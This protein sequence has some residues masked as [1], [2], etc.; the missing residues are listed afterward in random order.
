[1][2]IAPED[3]AAMIDVFDAAGN[4]TTV[5]A[6]G[7]LVEATPLGPGATLLASLA[8]QR[9]AEGTSDSVSC[10]AD[11]RYVAFVSS[12]TNLV[13]L[14]SN[15]VPDVFVADR[16]TGAVVCA[17]MTSGHAFGDGASASPSISADGRYVAFESQASNL[18]PGDTNSATDVF[19]CDL[20]TQQVERVSDSGSAPPVDTSINPSIS[21]DGRYVAF[22]SSGAG[23]LP[24]DTDPDADIYVYDRQTDTLELDTPISGTSPCY[25]PAISADGRYVAFDCVGTMGFPNDTNGT[26]DAFV[27]DRTNGTT[28]RVSQNAVGVAGSAWSGDV[29]ISA[30]GR[31]VSFYTS[32]SNLVPGHPALGVIDVYLCD[33]QTHTLELVSWSGTAYGD[34]MSRFGSVSADGRYVAFSSRATN[35]ASGSDT[36]GRRTSSSATVCSARSHGSAMVSAA[37]RPTAPRC[38]RP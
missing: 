36:N 19:V 3:V 5:T 6:K 26:D 27:Y 4:V 23:L 20:Q 10:S 1:M 18:A 35:L 12:A 38:P 25:R 24:T 15:G 17:S 31:Y 2:G 32:S 29:S 11:G 7:S 14:D 9:Q 34:G 13:P 37:H 21:A 28:E 30:D 16:Q 33:R 8:A 22:M